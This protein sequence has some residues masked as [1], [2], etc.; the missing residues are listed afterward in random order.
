MANEWSGRRE[1]LHGTKP[2]PGT[3]GTAR[4]APTLRSITAAN[5]SVVIRRDASGYSPRICFR[6]S[7]LKA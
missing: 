7:V 2:S 5:C 1:A 4:V 3:F 6:G